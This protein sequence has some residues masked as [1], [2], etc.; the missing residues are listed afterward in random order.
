MH[1][2]SATAL[3]VAFLSLVAAS[4]VPAQTAP[5]QLP[6]VQAGNFAYLGKFT[7]PSTDSAGVQTT[8]GGNALAMGPDGTSLYYGCVYGG[9]VVRVSIPTIGGVATQVE[10]CRGVPNLGAINPTDPNAK[11][12]G[13]VLAW[14][15]RLI[16]SGYSYYDGNSSAVASHFAGTRIDTASGPFRVGTEKPGLV[17]GY[18][19]VIPSEWRTLLGGP[20][21]TGQCCISIVSR[22]SH[23]PSVSVFDPAQVGTTSTV[24]S[25]MLV[26]YPEAHTNPVLG[27]YG[28]PGPM[29]SGA[30]RMGGVAFPAGTRSVL[31]VG[32]HGTTYCYGEG[33]TNPALDRQ[34][35]PGQT[36][37]IYCYD[38]TDSNK[39]THGYPY[40]HMAW[41]YDAVDLLAVKQ[42]LKNPWDIVP[43]ATWTLPEVTGG[44]GTASIRGVTYDPATRRLYLTQDLGGRTPEVHVYEITNAV[45][46]GPTPE[47]CGDGIDNDLDGLIDEG[48]GS[49]PVDEVCGDGLDN[50]GDGL[51]DEGCAELTGEVCGDLIDNDGDGLI[52]ENCEQAKVEICGDNID[53]DGD[54][55]V[56][57]GCVTETAPPGVPVGVRGTVKQATV[58][59]RWSPPLTGGVATSYVVEAGV[60]PGQTV[61]STP[62][63]LVTAV[64]V[65]NVGIG[66]YYVR[67][68]AKNANGTSAAS[69]EVVVSVGCTTKPRSVSGLSA[70]SLGGLV[71]L[72]WSDADGCSGST[73][74][75]ALGTT[76]GASDVR[77]LTAAET[78]TSTQLPQGTYFARVT[79]LSDVGLSETTDLRFDVGGNTCVTP[80]FRTKLKSVVSGRRVSLGWTP[81]DPDTANADDQLAPVSYLIEAGSVSGAANFGKASMERRGSFLNNVPPGVYFVRVRPMNGC[82]VGRASN[83][84]KVQVR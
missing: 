4:S 60:A 7:L 30:T 19:G 22:S 76:Q 1:S 75:V 35:V 11:L 48:C 43:Y 37:V 12:L 3:F 38:P 80:R 32:R 67:V 21:L 62:V 15:G 9:A 14:S 59:L 57:E 65:P 6:L 44:N 8:Y 2:R 63:G 50:D 24:T 47:I 39:G 66:K 71:N 53:N 17:A 51:I 26:G 45:L 42:G 46:Q 28:A 70:T 20:A 74:S 68:R 55:L 23:G 77:T 18:M 41:A 5:Q 64:S 82:G 73:Y 58:S 33:T 56:D 27:S 29:F 10:A 78:T 52:D 54:G 83:E 36:G 79:V 40:K 16:L 84:V 69:K 34:P 81:L 25:T 13:G 72:T 61:Y 31:F 49:V